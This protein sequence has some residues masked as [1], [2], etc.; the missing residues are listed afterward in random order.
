MF[1]FVVKLFIISI[2]ENAENVENGENASRKHLMYSSDLY[3]LSKL[4]V[5]ELDK[6]LEIMIDHRIRKNEIEN[7][8]TV[9]PVSATDII[10][11]IRSCDFCG[12]STK[13]IVRYLYCGHDCCDNV[14]CDECSKCSNSKE[15]VLHTGAEL[16]HHYIDFCDH[17]QSQLLLAHFP[18]LDCVPFDKT[19]PLPF[20]IRVYN[21]D[22]KKNLSTIKYLLKNGARKSKESCSEALSAASYGQDENLLQLLLSSESKDNIINDYD[23]LPISEACSFGSIS[24][25]KRFVELDGEKNGF[26]GVKTNKSKWERKTCLSSAM[27]KYIDRKIPGS[28]ETLDTDMS[29]EALILKLIIPHF[30]VDE[31]KSAFESEMQEFTRVKKLRKRRFDVLSL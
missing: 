6:I 14:I 5:C 8:K 4:S 16:L 26:Q 22:P 1:R 13:K 23:K 29:K 24:Y 19:F 15:C 17:I 10:R 9:N 12:K 20:A 31:Q 30:S 11:V 3:P 25:V 27:W 18:E 28:L 7:L 2:K 21:H